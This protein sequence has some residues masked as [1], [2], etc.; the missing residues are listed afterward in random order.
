MQTIV[1]LQ[2]YKTI[3]TY[4]TTLMKQQD[5]GTHK[6][7]SQGHCRTWNH[8]AEV[9]GTPA[10]SA[11]SFQPPSCMRCKVVSVLEVYSSNL[12]TNLQVTI[13]R[14]VFCHMVKMHVTQIEL[15]HNKMP[16]GR[17][18]NLCRVQWVILAL[19]WKGLDYFD[20]S[21]CRAQNYRGFTL[22]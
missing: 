19:K 13:L 4:T 2:P 6:E 7:L 15:C 16:C 12:V 5:E 18:I 20:Q 11:C 9:P 14:R 22:L 10:W 1:L 8:D 21:T 17:A 3:Y